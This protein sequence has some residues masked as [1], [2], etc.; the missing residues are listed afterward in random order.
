M[1][2]QEI[3]RK[4]RDGGALSDAEIGFFVDGLTAGRITEGQVAAFA[5][6]VFFKG[7]SR[8]ETVALTRAMAGSGRPPALGRP[9]GTG[10][11]QAFDRRGRRQGEPDAGARS[12]R[13]AA[14]RCR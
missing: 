4:K 6:A 13:P 7:M 14:A 2:P 8:A 9:A 5:M 12:W 11:R 10:G 3:I 1:L